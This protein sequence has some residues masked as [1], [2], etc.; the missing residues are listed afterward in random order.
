[1]AAPKSFCARPG[2]K[3][4]YAFH[5]TC[6]TACGNYISPDSEAGKAIRREEA[7][8]VKAPPIDSMF[9]DRMLMAETILHLESRILEAKRATTACLAASKAGAPR[10]ASRYAERALKALGALGAS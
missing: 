4:A 3:V 8:R 2:C 5:E 1:M 6:A 7:T 9:F 10:T